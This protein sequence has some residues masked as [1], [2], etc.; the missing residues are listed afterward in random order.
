MLYLKIFERIWFTKHIAIL[1]LGKLLIRCQYLNGLY[2]SNYFN[3]F[4]FNNLFEILT[5]LSSIRLFR[6]KFDFWHLIKSFFKIIF[7][8][9]KDRHP[10]LIQISYIKE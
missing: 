5:K 6:F 2:L 10:I 8:N 3:T 9:W 1:E 4:N 7:D